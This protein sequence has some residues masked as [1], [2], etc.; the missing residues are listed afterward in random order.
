M[1]PVSYWCVPSGWIMEIGSVYRGILITCVI[2]LFIMFVQ[3]GPPLPAGQ[4]DQRS[5]IHGHEMGSQSGPSDTDSQI[6]QPVRASSRCEF[7]GEHAASVW[8]GI[9]VTEVESAAVAGGPCQPLPHYRAPC[10]QEAMPDPQ[11][12]NFS[13]CAFCQL[14]QRRLEELVVNYTQLMEAGQRWRPGVCRTST[15]LV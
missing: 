9:N 3:L 2:I 4:P 12:Y 7:R 15:W 1:R 8:Y 13:S 6:L 11:P 14:C 10:W 5:S